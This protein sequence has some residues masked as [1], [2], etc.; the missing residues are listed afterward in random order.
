MLKRICINCGSSSGLLPEYRESAR[1]LGR[2]LVEEGLD[3]VFGGA[4]VGLMGEVTNSALACGGKVIGVIPEAI[5]GK[6]GH[7][8]ISELHV[9]PSMHERKKLM[10]E[11]SDAF[12]GLPG[13]LGTLEEIFEI[14][15]WAQ[16]G[17]HTKP[18]GLLNLCGYFD[19]LLEFL[20]HSVEQRF[21][22]QAHR[23]MLLVAES[24]SEL[25]TQFRLY[26]APR[27]DKWIDLH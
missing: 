16:L 3:I 26:R 15:T 22:K 24:P 21:V 10:F 9:V 19:R 27:V 4:D 5:A 1:S 17:F 11:L 12:I 23:D 8:R 6:V 25:L 14:L 13:G 18:C 2:Q 20:D 7:E